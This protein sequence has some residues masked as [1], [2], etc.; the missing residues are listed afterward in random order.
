MKEFRSPASKLFSFSEI[1]KK[2]EQVKGEG[3]KVVFTNGCFDLLHI[4]HLRL[5]EAAKAEGDFLVVGVNSDKSVKKIKGELRPFL[6]EGERTEVVAA[7]ER[8]DAVVMFDED[9]PQRLIEA[10]EPDVLVKG[11]DWDLD[12][13]VG[14]D[15]VESKGGKVVQV[16]LVGGRSTTELARRAL[17][18]AAVK[19]AT[20]KPTARDMLRSLWAYVRGSLSLRLFVGMA[21]LITLF[22]AL[23]A[24]AF[25]RLSEQT[26]IWAFEE[27]AIMAAENLGVVSSVAEVSDDKFREIAQRVFNKL[28][29]LWYVVVDENH[30]VLAASSRDAAHRV[31]WR[32]VDDVL[33]GSAAHTDY[34]KSPRGPISIVTASL[35]SGSVSSGVDGVVQMCLD[36][37]MLTPMM[38]R[39]RALSWAYLILNV[40]TVAFVGSF[41]LSRGLF[42]PIE[43]T[44]ASFKRAKSDKKP[45]VER[46][47]GGELGLITSAFYDLYDR[48][49]ELSD[50]LEFE[51]RRAGRLFDELRRAKSEAVAK[52]RLAHVGQ[53]A[54]GVAHEIGNPLSSLK[55]YMEVLKGGV[56]EGES[57]ED[58]FERME[59]ELGRIESTIKG[60]LEFARAPQPELAAVDVQRVVEEAV[61]LIRVQREFSEIEVSLSSAHVP[62]VLGDSNLVLQVVRNFLSN[63]AK[64]GT[65][66]ISV[67]IYKDYFDLASERLARFFA[68]KDELPAAKLAQ[69]VVLSSWKV[70]FE[71]G[72]DVVK[73]EVADRG[74][75]IDVESLG[76]I[77]EPFFSKRTGVKG[78]GLGLAI[79]QRIAENL[80]GLIRI[81]SE[82]GKGT[83]ATLILKVW[84]SDDR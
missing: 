64:S 15:V 36:L 6:P 19:R 75:G 41:L 73:V 81:E 57:L 13:I 74:R 39:A 52:E 61:E 70:P 4:G 53:L 66:S 8:V 62:P 35:S 63:A 1:I 58:Y 71:R 7:L 3:K 27:E 10:I 47:L 26:L 17:V 23:L 72:Q 78:T 29:L 2:V 37:G 67:N 21:I 16:P 24:T 42:R 5:F 20:R 55:G 34:R 30:R 48:V 12:K 45:E 68:P 14:R 9:T 54:S 49:V 51:R 80:E 56:P 83:V 40:L 60:L 77:F 50:K 76:R 31:E 69:R 28:P 22:G 79:C 44:A 11:G 18:V 25:F 38:V 82:V 33:L 84:E 46:G 65:E 43:R 32:V 59:R